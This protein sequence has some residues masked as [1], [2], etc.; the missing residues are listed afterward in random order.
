MA[1]AGQAEG[2]LV[3]VWMRGERGA[4]GR[5]SEMSLSLPGPGA[6][7]SLSAPHPFPQR[8]KSEMNLR[9]KF[10]TRTPI[11]ITDKSLTHCCNLSVCV[12]AFF[13]KC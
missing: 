2:P 13:H 12:K 5:P 9:D 4:P 1:G 10:I 11:Q 7:L 8:S 3:C 6:N